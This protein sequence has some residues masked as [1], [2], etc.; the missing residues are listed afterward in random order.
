MNYYKMRKLLF[1]LL[2]LLN[3]SVY[4]QKSKISVVSHDKVLGTNL[5]NNTPITGTEY[6]FPER[7]HGFYI[8]T[9][10]GFLTLQLRG[11]SSNG[12]WLN[13]TGNIV[14][15]DLL[16]KQ[17]KWTK[18]IPYQ[19]AELQQ[20]S[21]TMIYTVSN[22]STCLDIRTGE[23][24]WEVNNSIY[25]VDPDL[26]LGIGYRYKLASG[27]TND[28]EGIDLKSGR[29]SWKRVINREYS[30]NDIFYTNDTTVLIVAAGLHSLNLKNGKGWDYNT[31]TGKKDYKETIGANAV[32]IAAGLLTGTFVTTSGY[33]LVR[34]V[35]SNVLA[36]SSC[37]YFSSK[38]QLAKINKLTGKVVWAHPFENSMS[39]KSSIYYTDSMVILVNKG[40]ALMGNR[41]INFGKPFLAAYD[42]STGAEKYLSFTTVKNDPI[43]V[44][45]HADDLIYL[46][47]K[48]R[49]AIYSEKD[50]KMLMERDFM[51]DSYGD[52]KYF[53]GRQVYLSNGNGFYYSLPEYDS[54][55]VYVYTNNGKIIALDNHLNVSRALSEDELYFCYLY[56]GDYKFIAHDKTTS[57][58]DSKGFK[59][60]ELQATSNAFLIGNTLYDKQNDSFLTVD[61]KELVTTKSNVSD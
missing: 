55:L 28:L 30:W 18:K 7:I 47:F 35:V 8:D 51:T 24:L 32:G 21:H 34:D 17:V 10:S 52:L 42:R 1:L 15:F 37:Y 50:G 49:V 6:I 39:G 29:I 45:W 26:N 53:V 43:C 54:T 38:E 27:Y 33:N 16:Q 2:L 31:E 4:S 22:K 3:N 12:K 41:Q 20:F 14:Q 60:A 23:D 40:Y 48:N 58:L 61:L 13:N 19:S 59:V 25:F 46:L 56:V 11:V 5:L 9:L 36:D 57:V 44:F